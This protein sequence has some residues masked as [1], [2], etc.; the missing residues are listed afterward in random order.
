MVTSFRSVQGPLRPPFKRTKSLPARVN[1]VLA[2][3]VFIV[4]Y[5]ILSEP[6]EV[7]GLKVVDDQQDLFSSAALTQRLL[8][9]DVVLKNQEPHIDFAEQ[10]RAIFLLSFGKAAAENT[11]LERCILSIRRRGDFHGPVIVLT[12]A[13]RERYNGVLDENV[14]VLQSKD[15]DMLDYFE[16]GK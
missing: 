6:P 12:D 4:T 7:P 3:F 15:D 13:P 10:R 14:V 2:L 5:V 16:N 9:G 11:L 8:Q 1:G